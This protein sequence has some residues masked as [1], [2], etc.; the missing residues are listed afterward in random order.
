MLLIVQL[1]QFTAHCETYSGNWVNMGEYF[2]EFHSAINLFDELTI[3]KS[4]PQ[5]LNIL[6][7]LLVVADELSKVE[8]SVKFSQCFL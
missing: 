4:S 3:W 6:P 2:V 1:R 7:K 5:G 8:C